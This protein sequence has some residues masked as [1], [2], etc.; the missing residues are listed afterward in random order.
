VITPGGSVR[1]FLLVLAGAL[2]LLAGYPAPAAAAVAA[3]CV[4][5]ADATYRHSFD[6][7]AGLATI[8][9]VHPLCPGQRQAFA[10]IS[11]TASSSSFSYPQFIYDEAQATIDARHSSRKL[12]VTVP[13][14]YFQV[15]L[16]FG[17]NVY[18]EVINGDSNYGNL[19]LGA[20]Y[21][22]GSHSAGPYGGDADGTAPC[23]PK[24]DITYRNACNGTF[25][26]TL[27]NDAGANIDAVFLIAGHRLRVA[28]GHSVAAQRHTGTLTI[29]DN[30]FTTN[31]GM[32][33]KP[34][35][36]CDATTPAAPATSPPPGPVPPPASGATVAAPS[37]TDLPTAESAHPGL[38]V[39]PVTAS[40]AAA[41]PANST[42]Y[43]TPLVI[44]FG[45]LL[46]LGGLAVLV[47]VL[48]TFRHG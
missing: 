21:G 16:I 13:G 9:A 34:P 14:C 42:D 27:A 48:R 47:R 26:A 4:T 24:P 37:S 40:S 23:A 7:G 25:T 45:I 30:T 29:R 1:R 32:W 31:I 2:S 38:L 5:A 35:T 22:I 33:Q 18:T 8:T 11:Y 19:K 41:L 6:G 36:G 44:G 20:P 3:S 46:M 12:A 43:S 17:S 15:D 10:L 39:T 28:P